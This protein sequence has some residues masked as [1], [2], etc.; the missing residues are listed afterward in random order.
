MFMYFKTSISNK[1]WINIHGAEIGTRV[2]NTARASLFSYKN[3]S[4]LELE[5]TLEISGSD[6]LIIFLFIII[7]IHS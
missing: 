3:I 1:S 5:R 7:I 2:K 4:M 6:L